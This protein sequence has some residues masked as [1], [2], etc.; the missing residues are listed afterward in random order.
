[1]NSTE[2]RTEATTAV[3]ESA[4]AHRLSRVAIGIVALVAFVWLGRFAGGYIQPFASWVDGLGIFGPLVFIVAYAA[5]VVAFVPASLL[6]LAAG[7]IFG[8]VQGVVY[9]FFAATIGAGLSF[10][11]ARYMARA[12]VE[13]RLAGNEKIGA[14]DRAVAAEGRKIVFLLRLVPIIPFNALNYGLGLTRVSFPDY[15]LGSFGMIP[16]TLLYVYSGKVAGD[17]AE[18]ASGT[19]VSQGAGYYAFLALGLVAAVAA[20]VVVTRIAR[21]ALNEATGE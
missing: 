8:V 15:L 6:T 12:A 19:T 3:S 20:T 18:L 2:S 11:V 10:L 5:A 21:R 16:G 4:T 17:V 1:V 9:V 7:A 14:I 13:R